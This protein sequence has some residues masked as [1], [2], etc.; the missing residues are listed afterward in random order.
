MKAFLKPLFLFTIKLEFDIITHGE[1]IY[2]RYK[3]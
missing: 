2:A 3:A 1:V